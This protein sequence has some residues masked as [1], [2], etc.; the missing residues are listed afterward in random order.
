[1]GE[2][3]SEVGGGIIVRDFD[4]NPTGRVTRFHHITITV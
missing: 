3:P 1:M 4:G 2:L